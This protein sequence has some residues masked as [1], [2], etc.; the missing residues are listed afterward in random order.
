M[1]PFAEGFKEAKG[2]HGRVNGWTIGG[3]N[4]KEFVYLWVGT[5]WMRM[6]RTLPWIWERLM[7]MREIWMCI[8]LFSRSM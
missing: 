6:C 3:E 8:T 4:E 7:N 1:G 2:Y 5:Q